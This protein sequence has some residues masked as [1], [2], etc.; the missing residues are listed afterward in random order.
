VGLRFN[1]N[2]G[3]NGSPGITGDIP[4]LSACT[5]IQVCDVATNALTGFAGG[6]I[7][8]TLINIQAQG[9]NLG[10]AAINA[11]LAALVAAG[12]TNNICNLGDIGNAAPTGQGLTDKATLISRGWDITTN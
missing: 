5:S 1:S 2:K 4:T 7:P 10:A 11:I 12:S 9:N 8:A 3:K 6:S